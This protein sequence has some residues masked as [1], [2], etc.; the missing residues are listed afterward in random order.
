M[1]AE[2]IPRAP[3]SVIDDS[4]FFSTLPVVDLSVSFEFKL[5]KV[6][7]DCDRASFLML[8]VV[9]GAAD[10]PSACLPA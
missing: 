6:L 4:G 1:G 5:L 10:F 7:V 3:T 8:F 9:A 2:W